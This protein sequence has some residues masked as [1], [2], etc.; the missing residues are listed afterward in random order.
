MNHQ[1]AAMGLTA[2]CAL[3]VAA[4]VAADV[5]PRAASVSVCTDQYLVAIADRDQVAAV[6][7]QATSAR[8]PVRE[9]A[10]GLPQ[11]LGSAEELIAVQAEVVLFDP[12]GYQTVAG[13]LPEYGITVH[14]VGDPLRL[15]DVESEIVRIGTSLGQQAIAAQLASELAARRV[16]LEANQPLTRPTA[17]YVTPGGSGAGA[18]TFVDAVLR[19]AG[20]R[21]LQAELGHEGW[22]RIPLEQLVATP[23]DV[24]VL[25]FF[26]SSDPGLADGF[27]RHPRFRDLLTHVPIIEVPAAP[28]VCA[29]PFLLD[30]AEYLSVERERRFP[31]ADE[32]MEQNP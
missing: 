19:L 25:S 24:L 16:A 7:W 18:N 28:W 29:G 4:P 6:S 22:R 27:L 11:T 20:F 13:L 30:A 15:E 17:L 23:P 8:S 26:A 9:R 14:R 21:N 31:S 12:Y 5:L 1:S 3:L 32:L 2:L 10:M